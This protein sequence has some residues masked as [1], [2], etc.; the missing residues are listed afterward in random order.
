MA[1]VAGVQVLTQHNDAQRTGANLAETAL[2]PDNVRA[3]SFVRLGGYPVQGNVLAQPLIVSDFEVPGLGLRNLLIVA[4][5]DN[6]LYAFDA[7]V[8]GPDPLWSFNAG[9]P[10]DSNAVTAT[11]LPHVG[12]TG[13]PVIDDAHTT[14]YFVAMTQPAPTRFVHTLF[15]LDL[16]TPLHGT[17]SVR[18]AVIQGDFGGRRV[19]GPFRSVDQLQRAALALRGD[20]VY[21]SF[22]S[23]DDNR[24]YD[25]MV[26]DFD[27]TSLQLR[28]FF[29]VNRFDPVAG[30]RHAA[31]GIWQSGG[32]PAFDLEGFLY[33]VTGNGK[34]TAGDPL[35]TSDI[36]FGKDLDSSDVKLN[37]QLNAVDYFTPSFK[38]MLNCRD[39]DL[40]V[41]GPMIPPDWRDRKGRIVRRVVHGSKQGILYNL[42]R[43]N[44]G[45]FHSDSNSAVQQ[46]SVFEYVPGSN[47]DDCSDDNVFNDHLPR[48]HIHSTP[49]YWNNGH[50]RVVYVASDWG[51]GVK[52]YAF[53]DDGT[54]NPTPLAVGPANGDAI[55]QL[56]LSANGAQAGLLWAIGCVDCVRDDPP[57]TLSA[58]K[59]GVLLAYDATILGPPIFVS[60]SIGGFARF[61]APTVANGRVYVPTFSTDGPT[62]EVVVFGLSTPSSA[63][64]AAAR[65]NFL[66]G[67]WGVQGN[68]ELLV[69]EGSF[70]KEYFRDN[71]SPNLPWHFLRS[72]GYPAPPG[73]LGPTP[74]SVSFIQSNFKGDGTH[75][76]FEAI[77][78]V[79]PALAFLPDRLDF[80]FLD[81][82]TSR[83]NGGFPIR[84]DGQDLA[85]ITGD[86]VFL[87]SD[88]G[89]Q[90]NFELLVPQGNVIRQ[91]F[92]NNDDPAFAWHSLR[93]FGYRVPP[94]QLGPTPRSVTLIQSNFKGDGVH[95]NF[96]AVVRVA[97]PLVTQPDTL[98]FWF[99]DSR[100]SRWNGPFPI[101][102]DG[103]P[104]TNV[105]GDPVLLQGNWGVRGNFELLVPQGNVIRQ[106]FRNNDDPAFA[107]HSLREFGYRAP[108]GELGPTPR[109]V[110]FIQSNFKGDRTHGNF[111]AIVRVA[112]PLVT[113][114]DTLDFWFLDSRTSR[115]QGPFPIGADG[116]AIFGVTG[117]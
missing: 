66:Q 32:G 29:Q 114:P 75:G 113:Q 101:L 99:L 1:A 43:D 92:R 25:G 40:S 26:L 38:E 76:N 88:W 46:V 34:T 7:D 41:S 8:P 3:G 24:V 69:P 112:P 49:V 2:T 51:L 95:G 115:W 116:Q 74:R 70:I 77:V 79:A 83:W 45:R 21:V 19:G 55:E 67:N 71:D 28:D 36:G 5:A 50:D 31:G 35:G 108:L 109:S 30:H 13:T 14:L 22:S 104:I 12:I 63:S 86:Q 16:R 33:V 15:A 96:E 52:A 103:E 57:D 6:M 98:D 42:N 39:L 62:S 37:P 47:S 80:L 54:L 105:T 102:I 58:G 68:F 27:T 97:P 9:P 85:N 20:R 106:Y 59:S 72:F 53:N 10:V 17:P 94:G 91:Y 61:N 84:P 60:D 73:E 64:G 44:L 117:N 87:Q 110:T 111:E 100:T 93:E 23:F 18:S 56:S 107:W 82:R 78:R 65:R 4:T 89:H 90:G 48:R 11:F 81:S